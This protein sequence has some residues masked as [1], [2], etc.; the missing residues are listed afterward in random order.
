MYVYFIALSISIISISS[1][2]IKYALSFQVVSIGMSSVA[3][4]YRQILLNCLGRETKLRK[5]DLHS[6]EDIDPITE[7]LPHNRLEIIRFWKC[8]FTPTL[9]NEVEFMERVP[10]HVRANCSNRFL[11]KL[12]KLEIFGR[13]IGQW[14][15][16]FECH[17]PLLT[18]LKLTCFHLGFPSLCQFKWSDAPNLWPNLRQLGLYGGRKT[19]KALES[20]AL[21][22]NYFN[23]LEKL[24]VQRDMYTGFGLPELSP[25]DVLVQPYHPPL[26]AGLHVQ[27]KV[28]L[29]RYDC[30]Y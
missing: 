9:T 5:L 29:N 11:P 2:I 17:R 26:P 22:L 19:M 8:T 1:N 16:L 30:N 24:I 13:C 4:E 18:E 6:C 12:K 23:N 14:S 21:H 20:I 27:T 28:T 25:V 10:A 3:V 15:R 7:L